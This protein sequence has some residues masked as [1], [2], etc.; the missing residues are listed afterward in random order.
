MYSDP[1]VHHSAENDHRILIN[2]RSPCVVHIA[3][4]HAHLSNGDRSLSFGLRLHLHPFFDC[5]ISTEVLVTIRRFDDKV[6]NSV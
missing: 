3:D 1:I 5:I 4:V 2:L 6:L